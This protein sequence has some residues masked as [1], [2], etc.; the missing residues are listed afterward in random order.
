[1]RIPKSRLDIH[2]LFYDTGPKGPELEG[3]QAGKQFKQ[4]IT[5]RKLYQAQMP[6][7]LWK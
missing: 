4:L 5:G 2:S 1:L 3:W 6:E 7:W